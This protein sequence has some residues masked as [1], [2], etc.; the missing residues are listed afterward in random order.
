[1]GEGRAYVLS[2]SGGDVLAL[3]SGGRYTLFFRP[4]KAAGTTAR[5]GDERMKAFIKAFSR[6]FLAFF[7]NAA[8]DAELSFPAFVDY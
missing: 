4:E 3:R 5:L 6:K 1:L 2:A 7:E 8:S